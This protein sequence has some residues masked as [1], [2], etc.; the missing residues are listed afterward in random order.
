MANTLNADIRDIDCFDLTPFQ[1]ALIELRQAMH[2]VREFANASRM[3]RYMPRETG[4]YLLGKLHG[5]RYSWSSLLIYRTNDYEEFAE[6]GNA[7]LREA[8]FLLGA[9][10]R[11]A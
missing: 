3:H 2:N 5:V 8:D 7:F 1:W 11:E 10:Q 6:I 4:K 9:Y